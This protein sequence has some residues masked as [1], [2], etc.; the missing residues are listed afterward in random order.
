MDVHASNVAFSSG[1]FYKSN[2]AIVVLVNSLPHEGAFLV[3]RWE[4]E[5]NQDMGHCKTPS[6]V[7]GLPREVINIP[8]CKGAKGFLLQRKLPKCSCKGL[9]FMFLWFQAEG[10]TLRHNIG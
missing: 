1:F 4:M 6:Q 2:R 8:L 10:F 3:W 5:L 7:L 9:D